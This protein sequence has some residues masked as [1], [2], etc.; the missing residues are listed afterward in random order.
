[1]H[2][3]KA[4]IPEYIF[5]IIILV[6]ICFVRFRFSDMAMERD[7]GEYAYAAAEILRGGFPYLD[8][9]N[10]KLPGVYY[11]YATIFFLF[12]KSIPAVRFCVLLLNIFNC[13]FILMVNFL[14]KIKYNM[15]LRK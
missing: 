9:Y 7:E 14:Y 6:F 11:F 2:F 4:L 12:G 10:M 1:M 13:F 15:D 5:F 8:F 3:K